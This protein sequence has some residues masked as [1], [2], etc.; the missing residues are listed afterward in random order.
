MPQ[1]AREVVRNIV[2]DKLARG[3]VK[4]AHGMADG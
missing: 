3:E 1:S 4:Q 2:K